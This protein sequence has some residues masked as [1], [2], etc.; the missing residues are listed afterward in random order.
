MEEDNRATCRYLASQGVQVFVEDA[1]A[2][3]HAKAVVIDSESVI[4][5]ICIWGRR[6]V[7]KIIQ[8]MPGH[9]L[10]AFFKNH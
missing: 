9:Y 10:F 6:S 5:H 1:A 8:A 3:L 7:S 2:T 4:A